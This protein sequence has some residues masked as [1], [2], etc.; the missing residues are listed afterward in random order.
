MTLRDDV[1]DEALTRLA[2]DG[3]FRISELDF[4]ESEKYT[5]RRTLNNMEEEG[6][7]ERSSKQSPIWRLGWKS[8]LVMGQDTPGEIDFGQTRER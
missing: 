4:D 7:V 8:K 2:A 6:W 3:K 1:W 5:I